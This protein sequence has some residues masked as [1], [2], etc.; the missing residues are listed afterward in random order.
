MESAYI[1]K[2][3][4]PSLWVMGSCYYVQREKQEAWPIHS[5]SISISIIVGLPLTHHHFSSSC[6]CIYMV[7]TNAANS[8]MPSIFSHVLVLLKKINVRNFRSSPFFTFLHAALPH[9][10]TLNN[11]YSDI[12][13]CTKSLVGFNS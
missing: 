9:S 8:S 1:H 13:Y 4:A 2:F 7:A 3:N 5:Y 10:W 11:T 6:L 12:I